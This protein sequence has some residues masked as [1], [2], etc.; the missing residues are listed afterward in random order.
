MM[1]L[2]IFRNGRVY[3]GDGYSLNALYPMPSLAH[4][5]LDPRTQTF[6]EFL[7]SFP[8]VVSPL[9]REDSFDPTT[10]IRRGRFYTPQSPSNKEWN[11][12]RVNHY[13]YGRPMGGP[14]A[15]SLRPTTWM[16]T[17]PCNPALLAGKHS[18]FLVAHT[19]ELRGMSLTP[20][21]CL[22]TKYYLRSDQR[23]RSDCCLTLKKKNYLTK[24][25]T[26]F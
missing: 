23:I 5:V 8:P 7:G 13:P 22:T 10:R 17:T 21:D 18:S 15:G 3:E 26:K 6:P 16:A 4:V 11:T 20:S 2:A 9:F 14:P 19:K 1:M 12:E 25:A 24:S